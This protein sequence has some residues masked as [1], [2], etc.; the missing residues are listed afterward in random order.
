PGAAPRRG[1]PAQRF[2]AP[3]SPQGRFR[4]ITPPDPVH[5]E[6]RPMSTKN[7]H[8]RT[9]DSKAVS[10]LTE[11]PLQS[12]QMAIPAAAELARLEAL[13]RGAAAELAERLEALAEVGAALDRRL[14]RCAEAA[15]TFERAAQAVDGLNAIAGQIRTAAA[16]IDQ[17]VNAQ[18]A[19]HQ[20]R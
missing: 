9:S 1:T 7:G 15:E 11:V 12:E 2:S 17:R 14:A 19:D 8:S 6:H 13:A 3:S 4:P 10:P 20:R 18:L 5:P 16:A